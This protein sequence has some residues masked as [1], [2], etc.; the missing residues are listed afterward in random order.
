M[1]KR[2]TNSQSGIAAI[3]TVV[4]FT[5]LISVIILSFVQIVSQDQKQ[6]SNSDLSNSAY[7]S[8]EAGIED[9]KRALE[10]YRVECL[11]TD[12]PAANCATLYT[13][14]ATGALSGA[15]CDSFQ[16]LDSVLDLNL[17]NSEVKVATNAEDDS[18]EQAYTCLKIKLDTDDYL[19]SLDNNQSVFIPLKTVG[20]QDF[21][22]IEINWFNQDQSQTPTIP[23]ETS[24]F[25]LPQTNNWPSAQPPIL[26]AQIIP[27]QRGAPNIDDIDN[28]SKAVF[29]YPSTAGSATVN[30]GNADATRRSQKYSPV[31]AE[32]QAGNTYACSVQL[33]NFEPPTSSAYDYYLRLTP[34]YNNATVQVRLFDPATSTD[35]VQFSG[36][37]PEIDSTGRANDVFRRIISRVSFDNESAAS[38][39]GSGFDVTQG[40]CKSFELADFTTY[41]QPN[42]SPSN[43][44]EE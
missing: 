1:Q 41:Y 3:F 4:F 40:F 35:V 28:D 17:Q 36:V 34:I 27:V 24:G 38:G 37:E 30:V 44:V 32:C 8:A 43:L 29:L 21:T 5:L 22:N 10:K 26:R 14:P 11:K 9:G 7:D 20:D 15:E 23:S 6:V 31:A 19:R 33:I 2:S 39:S 42:C 12:T 25:N 16:R 18:L 13:N